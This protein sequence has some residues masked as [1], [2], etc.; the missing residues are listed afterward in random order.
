MEIG[1]RL[2]VMGALRRGRTAL[3]RGGRLY[4]SD[5]GPEKSRRELGVVRCRRRPVLPSSLVADHAHR[6]MTGTLRS[7]EVLS[8]FNHLGALSMH[9]ERAEV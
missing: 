3:R 8:K 7:K 4:V 2:A 5:Q 1:L 6:W 9:R